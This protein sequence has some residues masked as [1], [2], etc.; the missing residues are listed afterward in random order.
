MSNH[1]LEQN[2]QENPHSFIM[3][4]F[5]IGIWGGVIWSL[6][7]HAV[8][9]F[10]FMQVSPRFILTSWINSSW[11]NG[12][13]GVVISTLLWGILSILPSFIYYGVLR[14]ILSLYVALLFGAVLWLMLVFVFRPIFTN[15]PSFSKMDANT[16]ITSLC[17]FVLYGLFVGYSIF[18][19]EKE[20]QKQQE[21]SN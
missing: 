14:K 20:I 13:L 1:R 18:Y 9:Y 7:G 17:L 2:Q 12:W 15:L 16:I 21:A 10:H 3:H 19:E 8:H 6:V 5:S 11:V 4:V